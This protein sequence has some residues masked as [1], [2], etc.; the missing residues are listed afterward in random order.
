MKLKRAEILKTFEEKH[1]IKKI[2]ILRVGDTVRVHAKIKEGDKERVQIFEGIVTRFTK[3]GSRSSITVRKISFGVGVERVFP[4]YSPTIERIEHV[5]SGHVRRARLYHLRKK[6]GKQAR[7]ETEL[8][9]VSSMDAMGPSELGPQTSE[10]SS[11]QPAASGPFVSNIKD[12][13]KAHVSGAT[14]AQKF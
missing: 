10:P 12:E 7:L 3:G 5:S 8:G 11:Q 13:K 1:K 9:G 2:Y 4:L 14:V 6:K